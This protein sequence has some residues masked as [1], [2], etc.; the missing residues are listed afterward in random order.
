MR[1]LSVRRSGTASASRNFE[2]HRWHPTSRAPASS[3]PSSPATRPFIRDHIIRVTEKA[4][5]DFAGAS[6]DAAQLKRML[7]L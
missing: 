2:E 5:D 7:G 1:V 4:F 3:W 6:T